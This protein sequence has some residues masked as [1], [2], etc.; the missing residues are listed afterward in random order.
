MVAG[1]L[2][3]GIRGQFF[4]TYWAKA[5]GDFDQRPPGESFFNILGR[6]PVSVSGEVWGILHGTGFARMPS[7]GLPPPFGLLGDRLTTLGRRR[8]LSRFVE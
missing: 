4:I 7:F 6:G 2:R 3:R 1:S 8:V 5:L